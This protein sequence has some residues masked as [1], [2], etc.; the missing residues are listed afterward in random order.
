MYK[1]ILIIIMFFLVLLIPF[2]YQ[3]EKIVAKDISLPDIS[4]S[5]NPS[6]WV[7]VDGLGRSISNNINVPQKN[8][9]VGMFYWTWHVGNN[10]NAAYN[11]NNIIKQNPT[12]VH[13]F[14]WWNSNYPA[15]SYWWNE[16]IYGYYLEVDD[17]V[18][19]KHA[20]LLAD[21]MVDFVVFDC[22]N[23]ALTWQVAYENLLKVWKEA[24]NDGI[25]VPKIAF[26]LP[27]SYSNNSYKSLMDIYNN[28]YSPVSSNYQ[29][30]HDLFFY[31]NSKPLLLMDSNKAP[32]DVQAIL[33][34]FTVR[35][36]NS[37][38]FKTGGLYTGEWDWLSTYPQAY[39]LKG[40][41]YIEQTSVSVA[42]NASYTNNTLT[43][44]NGNN[45]MGR[46]YAKGNYSY[47]Y[48]YRNSLIT[49]SNSIV[50]NSIKSS[51]PSLYGRNFQQ[52]W[53]YALSLDPEVIFVTG[54][55]EWIMGRFEKWQGVT[56]AFPD[57][58][59]DEYSRDIEP[60]NGELKDNYYYQLVS[61]IRKYKGALKETEQL[62]P[63]TIDITKTSDWDNA[64]IINYNHYVGGKR[65]DSD[66]YGIATKLHYNNDTFRNDI[67]K[68]KVSYDSYYIYFY[69]ETKDNLSSYTDNN[70]MRLLIDT[71]SSITNNDTDNWE[72][73]EYI[74][75]RDKAT[76]RTMTLEKSTGGWNFNK[77]GDVEY[78]INSNIL[79]I[80]I[81]R[82]YLGM[83]S[84]NISFN[85]KWCDNNLDNGD[86]MSIYTNGDAA[87]SGRFAFQFNGT[88][89]YDDTKEKISVDE[90]EILPK[91]DEIKINERITLTVN[92]KS[93]S[94]QNKKI[95]W[96]S[97]N[98]NIASIDENGNLVGINSGT[99][100]ISA[101]TM[102]GKYET[103]INITVLNEEENVNKTNY[104]IYLAV[105]IVL[106]YIISLLISIYKQRKNNDF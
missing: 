99:T 2:N 80:A 8:R 73:F 98:P 85:F 21:A 32:A 7:A 31:Y 46:S 29:K 69:V 94:T 103:S 76:E 67:V 62:Q 30:Y 38:Y 88:E 45:I 77:V 28:L 83:I 87:P 105:L 56:N 26:M 40:N 9:Y 78:T 6:K 97:S 48:T 47:S 53:D 106:G 51:N 84:D 82:K 27:F 18:L 81:P 71:K 43:A 11:V 52:Q 92:I 75:N 101:K 44:M 74:V 79:Q 41:N 34:N 22:T 57:Q 14:N 33:N 42:Q 63:V 39:Y 25:K 16:P 10:G 95:L 90:F 23:G 60:S 13:D 72:E 20:E 68:A 49:V 4:D 55:N 37:S 17:Y 24:Q 65:R 59:N 36:V 3:K 54:W 66:G 1:K 61:N 5:V 19:R 64:N 96:N 58:Y 104:L 70:F 15:N 93:N 86:I 12:R 102:D 91:V 35:K 50:G 100:V 89:K